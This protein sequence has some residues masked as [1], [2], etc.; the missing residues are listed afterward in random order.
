MRIYLD[1]CVFQDLK[2]ELNKNLLDSIIKSKGELIYCFSEAHIQ[3]LSRDKKDYKFSDMSFMEAIVDDN[4]FFYEKQFL[5]EH[6]TPLYYYNRFD[7]T[8]V[9]SANKSIK[10]F[11]ES[12]YVFGGLL[13][14]LFS[15]IPLNLKDLIPQNQMPADMP[16]D[17][18]D[19]LLTPSNLYE[20][21]LIMTEYSDSLTVEQKK[22]KEQLQY[23]HKNQ[24]TQNLNLIGI[25]GYDGEKIT[26]IKK[27]RNSYANYF[28]KNT[29]GKYRYDLFLDMYNGLELFGFV[30]GKPKKQKM[31]NMINDGRHAFFGGFCDIVVSKDEDFINKAKFMYNLHEIQVQV[32]NISE[33]SEFVE[34][35]N[36]RDNKHF[37]DLIEDL[38]NEKNLS[39][40]MYEIEEDNQFATYRKLNCTYWGYFNVLINHSNGNVYFTKDTTNFMKGTL[41]KEI[42]FC[43]NQLFQEL[44]K[45]IRLRGQ[46]ETNELK[47]DQEKEWHGRTWI[48]NNNIVVDLKFSDKLY[49]ILGLIEKG[50]KNEEINEV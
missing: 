41:I 32:Y 8:N 30:P 9:S 11:V 36:K 20:L 4:C 14:S 48:I 45:D 18:I 2:N 49:I 5:V 46:W 35:Q 15:A 38:D 12:N 24:L 47:K 34:T 25:E 22:F 3:D 23:L 6:Y 50:N 17:M 1:N 19:M 10:S 40:V 31:I 28:L 37:I 7:W 42:E 39:N 27:F 16:Q 26:D 43:V 33:F 29:K 21:M 13:K 44:G